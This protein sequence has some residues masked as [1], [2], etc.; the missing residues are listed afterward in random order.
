MR[1]KQLPAVN[2]HVVHAARVWHRLG[3]S[4]PL[5]K[6]A[7]RLFLLVWLMAC[8]SAQD[9]DYDYDYDYTPKPKEETNEPCK[10]M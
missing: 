1:D 4:R 3:F 10:L 8:V 2:D 6:A 5:I 9:Y 7:L